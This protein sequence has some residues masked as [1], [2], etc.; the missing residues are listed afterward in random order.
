MRLEYSI[1]CLVHR[2]VAVQTHF[3][4]F[5]NWYTEHKFYFDIHPPL[6]KL[7]FWFFGRVLGYDASK[8][9]FV[10][11]N[12]QYAPDCKYYILRFVAASFSTAS[13]VLMF[14]CARNLGCSVKGAMVAAMLLVFDMI[15][16]GEGR[17]ILMDSQLIFWLLATLLVAQEW[18]KRLNQHDALLGRLR[19]TS[20][21]TQASGGDAS[22]GTD[23]SS[24]AALAKRVEAKLASAGTAGGS[25]A[26]GAAPMTWLE[27]KLWCV[28]VGVTCG[29]AIN[30][31]MTGLVTPALIAMESFFGAWFLNTAVP[32]DELLLTLFSA[33]LTYSFWFA[34]SFALFQNSGPNKVEQEFMTPLVREAPAGAPRGG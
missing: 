14:Y 6:G 9:E 30:I 34:C 7:A 32:F 10:D 2:C 19:I 8:C 26:G 1:A 17:L 24:G 33:V 4:K 11:L 16:I 15:N 3:G 31:K 21:W 18:W 12:R 20:T 27:R 25:E 22:G 23:I 5:T 13:C 29:N 28:A